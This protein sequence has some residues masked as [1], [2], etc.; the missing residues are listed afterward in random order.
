MRKGTATTLIGQ[1]RD[2]KPE[3]P[4]P[5]ITIAPAPVAAPGHLAYPRSD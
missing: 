2:N 5:K 1:H 3:K 4:L